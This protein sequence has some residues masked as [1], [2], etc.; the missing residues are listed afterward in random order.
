[1]ACQFNSQEI[2]GFSGTISLICFHIESRSGNGTH[3]GFQHRG[4]VLASAL[5]SPFNTAPNLRA[6]SAAH[7]LSTRKSQQ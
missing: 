2:G 1:M 6:S 5:S 7:F 3:I 4:V